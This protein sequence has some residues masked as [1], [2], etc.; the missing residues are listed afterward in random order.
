MVVNWESGYAAFRNSPLWLNDPLGDCPECNGKSNPQE[1]D[2]VNP[3]GTQEYIYEN[4]EWY[5][6]GG[7]LDEVEVTASRPRVIDGFAQM[8]EGLQ[9]SFSAD[10]WNDVKTGFGQF[11]EEINRIDNGLFI[12][13]SATLALGGGGAVEM[14]FVSTADQGWNLYMT[15]GEAIGWTPEG[16]I[17]GSLLFGYM[18]D[19]RGDGVNHRDIVGN[20]LAFSG[21]YSNVG[22]AVGGNVSQSAS[23]GSR[24]VGIFDEYFFIGAGASTTPPPGA[25]ILSTQ[26][27]KLDGMALHYPFFV[28][29]LSQ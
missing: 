7:I 24:R 23:D 9:Y 14:S 12:S 26:T 25:A 27:F 13:G 2:N 19:M 11:G 20:E 8:G 10:G 1:G 22:F 18:F 17:D 15:S 29:L 3:N 4:G 6:D 5:A 28:P 16:K 21:N